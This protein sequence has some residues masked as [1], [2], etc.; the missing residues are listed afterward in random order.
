M[1][2]LTVGGAEGGGGGGARTLEVETFLE[3]SM[4]FVVTGT[5]WG[6]GLGCDAAGR[7]TG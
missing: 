2:F 1:S 6:T 7:E 3:W 5:G 4:P